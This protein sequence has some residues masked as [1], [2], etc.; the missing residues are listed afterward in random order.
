MYAAGEGTQEVIAKKFGV[1]KSIVSR[2]VRDL[3]AVRPKGIP[4]DSGLIAE[5]TSR[6]RKILWRQ[7][8]SDKVNF[9]KWTARV[10]ELLTDANKDLT[11]SQAVIWASKEYPCLNR[12]LSDYDFSAIDPCPELSPDS[13]QIGF[14]PEKA[15]VCDGVTQSHRDS[16][17]WAIDAAGM[18]RRTGKAP[19]SCPCDTAW[20]L[21]VSAIED[22]KDFLGKVNQIE[23]KGDAESADK[24]AVRQS[25]ERCIKEINSMLDA[26][27]DGGDA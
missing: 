8:G 6:A 9:D 14:E 1:G 2:I 18:T 27:E 22:P 3:K 17:R 5:F 23:A 25:G 15:V 10:Q 16:L 11:K 12:L 26:M 20:Y 4:T 7:D 21:Y 24:R 13:S 19:Q